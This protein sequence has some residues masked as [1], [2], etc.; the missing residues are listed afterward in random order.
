[1]EDLQRVRRRGMVGSI[2]SS[3][4]NFSFHMISNLESLQT[5]N[6][7]VQGPHSSGIFMKAS[8]HRH[9]GLCLEEMR[10]RAE[11]SKPDVVAQSLQE[12][13]H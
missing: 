1:M 4:G 12:S 2:M 8:S 9:D 5:L 6:P 13:P 10:N 3:E 11:S 7:V